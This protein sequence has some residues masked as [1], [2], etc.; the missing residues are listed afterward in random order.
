MTDPFNLRKANRL[1]WLF[2]LLKIRLIWFVAPRIVEYNEKR[3]VVRIPLNW[4]TRN[5]L[6]SMYLG[7]LTVGADIASGFYAFHS[8][9]TKGLKISLAFKSLS[10][11][12]ISRPESDVY[13]IADAGT[14]V[15]EMIAESKQTGERINTG[16]EVKAVTDFGGASNEVAK[17]RMELS[18][19]AK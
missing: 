11:D 2:G 14:Q 6:G 4:R 1:L 12:F 13:F 10:A 9:R 17:F 16:I 19:K 18:I 7:V 8:S 5:H 3:T 15:D